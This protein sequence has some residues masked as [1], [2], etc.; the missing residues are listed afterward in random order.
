MKIIISV[1]HNVNFCTS[2]V[3]RWGKPR[4]FYSSEMLSSNVQLYRSNV[5]QISEIKYKTT[6]M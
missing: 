1:E 2:Q 3:F 4:Q 6:Y 5:S